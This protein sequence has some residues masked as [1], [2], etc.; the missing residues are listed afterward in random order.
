MKKVWPPLLYTIVLESVCQKK[1]NQQT[2]LPY[3]GAVAG[4]A[5]LSRR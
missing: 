5:N 3:L 1:K 4:A 2:N